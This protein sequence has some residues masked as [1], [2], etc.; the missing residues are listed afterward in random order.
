MN[1]A[2]N[3]KVKEAHAGNIAINLNGKVNKIAFENHSVL[4][5]RLFDAIHLYKHNQY[6]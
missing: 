1:A 5:C 4:V 2:A 3:G 6:Q